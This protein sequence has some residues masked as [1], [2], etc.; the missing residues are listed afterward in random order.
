M[1]VSAVENRNCL[2]TSNESFYNSIMNFEE[3]IYVRIQ[4]SLL[5]QSVIKADGGK[6]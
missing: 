1:S 6:S 4:V 5:T 2:P 3:N